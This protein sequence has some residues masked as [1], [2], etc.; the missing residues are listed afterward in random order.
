MQSHTLSTGVE[1]AERVWC[2]LA[3]QLTSSV[4]NNNVATGLYQCCKEVQMSQ[5]NIFANPDQL[6]AVSKVIKRI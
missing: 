4:H 6:N 3:L 5:M 1:V 2:G